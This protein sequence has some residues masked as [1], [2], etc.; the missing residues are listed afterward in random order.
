V[1]AGTAT[2]VTGGNGQATLDLPAGRYRVVATKA[3]LVRSF[4]ERV[5]VP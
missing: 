4:G 2:A 3:G 5:E 1:K